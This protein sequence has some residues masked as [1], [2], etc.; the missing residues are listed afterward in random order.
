MMNMMLLGIDVG[1]SGCKASLVDPFGSIVGSAYRE[2][3][4]LQETNSDRAQIDPELV[5]E[6]VRSACRQVIN[7]TGIEEVAAVGVTSFG[8]SVVFLDEAGA[9]L[10]D[11]IYYYDLR[12]QEQTK[13]IIDNLDMKNFYQTTGVAPNSTYSLAKVM[14][15]RDNQPEVYKKARRILLFADFILFRMGAKPCCSPSLAA[16]TMACDVF[17]KTWASSIIAQCGIDESLF[18]PIVPSG[19]IAGQ[20]RAELADELGLINRPSLVVGGHDQIFAAIGAGAIGQ[21]IAVDGLG[22]TECITPVFPRPDELARMVESSFACVPFVFD[23]TYVTY[24]YTMTSGAVLKWF[25]DKIASQWREDAEAMNMNVY[26]YMIKQAL[27]KQTDMLLLP[28]FAGSATPYMD[29]KS[30]GALIGLTLDTDKR[31]IL[32]AVLEGINF[33]MMIN[34]ERLKQAGIEIQELRVVGGLSKSDDFL[35]LK[36]DMMGLKITRVQTHE[37]GTLGVALISSVAIGMYPTIEAAVGKMVKTTDVF[38]PDM[39]RNAEYQEKYQ[40][41]K[42]L[43]D[44]VRPLV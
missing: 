10:T 38:H 28:H 42:K 44:A 1:T 8:E 40:R 5:W 30:R 37:A 2:Y 11:S 29:N 27:I 33:E 20:M 43:Y 41:Y 31:E 36:A 39:K 12:G 24:A 22:T 35:Q 19:S 21:G 25:R 15:T 4:Q 26:D 6:A 14:W 17:A 23:Q 32:R 13:W 7:D 16:R 34:I 18:A 3:E 9:S